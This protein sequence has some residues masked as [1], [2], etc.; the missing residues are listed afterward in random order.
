MDMFKYVCDCLTPVSGSPSSA[1]AGGWKGWSSSDVVPVLI[2]GTL[3]ENLQKTEQLSTALFPS[4]LGL[5]LYS[6]MIYTYKQEIQKFFLPHQ[7][8][9]E[10]TNIISHRY[11]PNIHLEPITKVMFDPGSNVIMTSSQSDCSSVVFLNLTLKREPYVW[12][13]N[14]VIYTHKQL[15][16]PYQTP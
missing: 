3:C 1:D 16:V 2:E 6:Y 7:D 13:I 9:C 12:R 4:M 14:Q 15:A 5:F 8:L 10:N 11:I